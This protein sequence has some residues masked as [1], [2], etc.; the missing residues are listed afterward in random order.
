VLGPGGRGADKGQG[1]SLVLSILMPCKSGMQD[2]IGPVWQGSD[3][4]SSGEVA[5]SV[6][7]KHFRKCLAKELCIFRNE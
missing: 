2:E 6:K 4:S 1:V 5:S 7:L 3:S